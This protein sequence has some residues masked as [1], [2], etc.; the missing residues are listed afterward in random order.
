MAKL[1]ATTYPDLLRLLKGKRDGRATIGNNTVAT[2]VIG[3][4]M[5]EPEIRV[6]LHGKHIVTLTPGSIAYS[7]AGWPTV[8]TRERINHFLPSDVKVAQRKNLPIRWLHVGD[9]FI[10]ELMDEFAWYT[11]EVE[12]M[13]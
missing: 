2:I 4:D 7:L 8:T 5:D 11:L 12:A 10:Y 13:T 9:S 6:H 1:A 3:P